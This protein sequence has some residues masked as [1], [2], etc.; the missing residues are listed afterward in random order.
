MFHN[1][2]VFK[3]KPYSQQNPQRNQVSHSVHDMESTEINTTFLVVGGGIAGVSCCETLRFLCPSAQVTLVTES[4][5]I[6]TVTNLVPLGKSLTRFDVS[7]QSTTEGNDDPLLHIISGDRVSTVESITRLARTDKGRC[8][9]YELMCV[10][11]G[12]RPKIIP[13]SFDHADR[14][15]GIR[16]TESVAQFQRR[17]RGARRIAIVGNGGI[18][19]ECAYAVSGAAVDWVI[20]DRFVAQTFVDPGAAEFFRERLERLEGADGADA[21][22]SALTVEGSLPAKAPVKRMRYGETDE[23]GEE[24]EMQGGTKAGAA[25]GPD[26]HSKWDLRGKAA[27]GVDDSGHTARG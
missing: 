21:G 8:I 3:F 26:W 19:A 13:Q 17:V 6:K 20:R 4:A 24:T 27:V 15:L 23:A 12:A 1:K 22:A 18:A 5:L 11:T 7:E 2:V 9:R 14:V 25:L 16:D 10:C